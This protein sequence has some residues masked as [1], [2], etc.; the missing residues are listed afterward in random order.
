MYF[1]VYNKE[2]NTKLWKSFFVAM[3][4][5]FG[6]VSSSSFLVGLAFLQV[7]SIGFPVS[8]WLIVHGSLCSVYCIIVLISCVTIPLRQKQHNEEYEVLRKKI[9]GRLR[10][11]NLP[12]M[13]DSRESLLDDDD[14]ME[15]HRKTRHS[16]TDV[17][18]AI[19]GMF[20]VMS[21]AAGT[22]LVITLNSYC[23]SLRIYTIFY[24]VFSG[25]F[26]GMAAIRV[27]S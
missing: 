8:W 2:M 11:L 27:C 22:F 12:P 1:F 21:L 19:F 20:Y 10:T 7:C 23:S 13:Q 24:I 16:R 18:S 25:I 4:L 6:I 3:H 5:L 15:I 17:A 14:A 9:D 26:I